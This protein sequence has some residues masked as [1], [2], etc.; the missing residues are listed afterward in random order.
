MTKPCTSEADCAG[1]EATYCDIFVSRSC[2][3]QGCSLD[4]DNCFEGWEC[5]DLSAFGIPMPLC[6]PLGACTT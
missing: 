5:C 6:L 4:P 2:L 3:V 1:T